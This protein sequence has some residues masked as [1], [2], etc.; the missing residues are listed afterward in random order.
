MGRKMKKTKKRGRWDIAQLHAKN[1]TFASS[2]RSKQ[3]KNFISLIK[4]VNFV[5]ETEIQ[6]TEQGLKYVAAELPSFQVSAYINKEFFDTFHI[7]LPPGVKIISFGVNLSSFTD[8]LSAFLDNDLSS[9]KITY[10][11]SENSIVFTCEQVDSGE[12][13]LLKIKQGSTGA[14]TDDDENREITTEY[15]IQAMQSIYPVDFTVGNLQKTSCLILNAVD[16][17]NIIND[18]DRT[19]E[20]LEIKITQQRLLLKSVGILQFASVVKLIVTS[21]V[22]EKFE[23]CERSKFTFKFEYFK[24]IMKVRRHAVI[25]FETA[26]ITFLLLRPCRSRRWSR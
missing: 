23:F 24:V 21:D 20:A 10:Y 9:M 16:F 25:W 1:I 7:K 12:Q 6:L 8:L 2:L 14:S 15:F 3:I 18:F 26:K 13:N 17:F 19:I 4:A 11:D 5:T 22:F